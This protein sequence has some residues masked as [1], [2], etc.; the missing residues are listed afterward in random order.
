MPYGLLASGPYVPLACGL[1]VLDVAPGMRW[2]TCVKMRWLTG[3]S[4]ICWFE[5]SEE[6]A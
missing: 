3:I 5:T 4:V 1:G 2:S 6:T